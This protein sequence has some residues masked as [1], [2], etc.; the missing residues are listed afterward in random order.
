M[1]AILYTR[2]S[3]KEQARHGCSMD[4]QIDRGGDRGGGG[5]SKMIGKVRK[6]I[7]C[8]DKKHEI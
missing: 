3:T 7:N 1:K 5:G 6:G 2:A 8:G 4:G